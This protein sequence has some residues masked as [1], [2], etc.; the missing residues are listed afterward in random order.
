MPDV[1]KVKNN[2]NKI[3]SFNKDVLNQAN[4]KLENAYAL[5]SQSDNQDLGLQIGINLM[6][7]LFWALGSLMG[8]LGSIPANFLSGVVSNYATSQPPSLNTVFSSIL[9]RLQTT[10]NQV[11]EDLAIYYQDPLKYWDQTY[12]GSFTT[13][14]GSYNAN[15][16]LGDLE[17]IDFPDQTNPEYYDILKGCIKALDQT[18]WQILLQ[19]FVNT[20][21]EESRP[22]MWNLP[23]DP[24]QEDNN[25]LPHQKSYYHTWEYHEDKDCHGNLVKYYDRE[26]YNIGTGASTWSDGALNDSACNYLF[27]N[28]SSDT[29]NPDGLFERKFVFTSLGIPKATQ[30]INNG[31]TTPIRFD[32]KMSITN[33]ILK[34]FSKMCLCCR[35]KKSNTSNG[36]M[37]VLSSSK[38]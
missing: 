11:N 33:Y 19:K 22:V 25:F 27:K 5:L 36:K 9:T 3:I 38:Q 34:T 26:E 32:N 18:M 8:P 29:A 4:M 10:I 37:K 24:N 16:K 17:K 30:Y 7:G 20:H 21:Y 2:I 1:E 15:G 14:F 6:G 35:V 13:P 28:Y 31:G 12:G 23:C